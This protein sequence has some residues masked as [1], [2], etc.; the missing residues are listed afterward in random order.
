MKKF[1]ELVFVGLTTLIVLL[2]TQAITKKDDPITV[3]I[4]VLSECLKDTKARIERFPSYL[5]IQ[6][7]YVSFDSQLE[8]HPSLAGYVEVESSQK[9]RQ[10]LIELGSGFRT[11]CNIDATAFFDMNGKESDWDIFKHI[12]GAKRK[13]SDVV[14]LVVKDNGIE[15]LYK[16][17]HYEKFKEKQNR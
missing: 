12:N 9:D 7:K 5:D 1:K 3:R 4:P 17:Q 10:Y 8:M 6:A 16:G 11:A 15:M 2:S 13:G 14:Y